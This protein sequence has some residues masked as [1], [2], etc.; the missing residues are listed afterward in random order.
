MV[1]KKVM[2][3]IILL[4]IAS[5]VYAQPPSAVGTSKLGWDQEAITL[6]EAQG[7]TY[8]YYADNATTG[9][10]LTS[11]VCAGTVSPFQCEAPFPAFTPGNHS[12]Q[13]STSNLAGESAKSTPPLDFTFVVTPATPNRVRIIQK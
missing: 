11:V 5:A 13:L 12:L 3:A 1:M 6:A 7:Y 8:K 2:L 10:A 9:I 4:S